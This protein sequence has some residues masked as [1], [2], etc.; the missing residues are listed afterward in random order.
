MKYFLITLICFFNLKSYSQQ[1]TPVLFVSEKLCLIYV[2]GTQKGTADNN[3]PLLLKLTFG[4]HYFQAK[5]DNETFTKVIKCEDA[6]QK[7]VEIKFEN[8]NKQ[9]TG[10]DKETDN[11]IP[12]KT[13]QTSI[14]TPVIFNPTTIM[15]NSIKLAGLINQD[16]SQPVQFYFGFDKG[17]TI[18]VKNGQ[19]GESGTN[20]IYIY[21]YP[22]NQ[23][24]YFKESL[25]GNAEE[26]FII[27]SK[28]VYY[29]KITTNYFADKTSR[30]KVVR[31]PS[32]NSTATF[33]TTPIIKRDTSFIQLNDIYER[34]EAGGGFYQSI[35]LP[36]NTKFWVYW[37]GVG[38]EAKIKYE[39]FKE[40][41]TKDNRG[42][43]GNPL[44]AY[45]T[46]Q[47]NQLPTYNNSNKVIDYFFADNSNAQLFVRNQS[48]KY[49]AF[50]S[51]KYQ[52]TD[53]SIINNVPKD[54]NL[55]VKATNMTGQFVSMKIG[56]FIVNSFYTIAE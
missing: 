24:L 37:I 25:K 23:Q 55:I 14:S 29:I 18:Q 6:N 20:N 32:L 50:K 38:E 1:T 2:D 44:Y 12:V 10:S 19:L 43:N 28:G 15:D 9:Q 7:V 4:E 40:I 11:T 56:A 39:T 26:K 30:I 46:N 41:F 47:I 49:Y 52:T 34:I 21:S 3:N 48:F 54:L 31:F 17:D 13:P 27:P 51:G 16:K 53:Y 45:G 5:R 33:N 42:N 35:R 36:Q 22:N 8:E